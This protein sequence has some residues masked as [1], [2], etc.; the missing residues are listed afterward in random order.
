M[1]GQV[2]EDIYALREEKPASEL[3][4]SLPTQATGD[5]DSWLAQEVQTGLEQAERGEF[6]SPQA[7]DAVFEKYGIR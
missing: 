7:V 5:Y 4:M 1:S 6:A 2:A 3:F